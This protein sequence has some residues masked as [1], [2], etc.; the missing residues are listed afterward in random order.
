[1]DR[2]TLDNQ[3]QRSN[4]PTFWSSARMP[5]AEAPAQVI[6]Q[7]QIYGLP[8]NPMY[9]DASPVHLK[10]RYLDFVKIIALLCH[11]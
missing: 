10:Q 2:L 7:S 9:E 8:G 1:M 5:V 6:H 11:P 3:C 4:Y